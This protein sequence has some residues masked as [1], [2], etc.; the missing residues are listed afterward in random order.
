MSMQRFAL[1]SPAR[2]AAMA[3]LG[4]AL[5]LGAP[6]A[7]LTAAPE[8]AYAAQGTGFSDVASNHWVASEGWLGYATGNGLLTG[9]RD[10]SGRPTGLFGPSD[11]LTRG[12]VAAVLYRIANP[13]SDATSNPA[14]YAASTGFKDQGAYPYYRAAVRWLRDKG[15]ATGDKDPSTQKPLNTFRPD[16]PVTRQELAALV[17]RFCESMGAKGVDASAYDVDGFRDG[18]Q[19]L[20]YARQAMAW[21]GAVG[22]ITGGK[23]AE[24]GLLMPG[25]RT[26]RA[27]AAKVLS[28][29]N[30]L[31]GS[32]GARWGV[33]KG[34]WDE[35]VVTGYATSD[36]KAF[37]SRAEAD[38][39]AKAASKTVTVKTETETVHHD[40]V[41]KQVTVYRT[42]DGREFASKSEADAHAKAASVTV[43]VS[44]ETKTVH[45][46]ATYKKVVDKPAWD[47]KKTVYRT[48]D[49][50]TFQTK[51]EAD[52]H[53]SDVTTGL[54]VTGSRKETRSVDG[55]E[56]ENA[57]GEQVF[58]S[59]DKEQALDYA[60]YNGGLVS[61]QPEDVPVTVHALSDGR[62]VVEV[63]VN[64]Y[65]PAE[66]EKVPNPV[67]G[68]RIWDDS[69]G[70]GLGWYETKAEAD[71]IAAEMNAPYA[72][73]GYAQPYRVAADTLDVG[74]WVLKSPERVDTRPR[75][76]CQDGQSF[77]SLDEAVA[78][79]RATASKVT[80]SESV[81][82]TH[83]DATYKTVVDRPAWDEKVTTYKTS[84]G[85]SF[86]NKKDADDHAK[87][88][89]K[90]VTVSAASKKV[91]D[92]AAYDE[93][94][95]TYRT[96][97]GKAFKSKSEADAHAKATSK[98][99]TVTERA[100]TVRHPAIYGWLR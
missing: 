76:D 91:V 88:A 56:T 92:K 83:H 17:Q 31:A 60:G 42:S 9:Y 12:Q 25:D 2:A 43:T 55:W 44:A 99:V 8:A 24:A 4:L 75:F 23:G 86:T 63:G 66:Y 94:V 67:D 1:K 71:R 19:V 69:T 72:E 58:W 51:A 41:Y 59:V 68:W 73:K 65:V 34:A 62:E 10:A 87:A 3:G 93:K 54:R 26:T 82:V 29:A 20:P 30:G 53:I 47:E 38:A 5:A 79:M 49:G 21:C 100:K 80:V 27:Q 97:D 46:E 64:V 77:D 18:S 11:T 95:V 61:H 70:E 33:T 45:H 35:R 85:K 36:G 90:K 15:I 78:H 74:K 7:A 57:K 81:K 22:A 37:K 84:D 16:D 52:A 39:H 96:S 14:H 98:T 13:S 28:V 48:S 32:R 40:A 6:A 50:K 89:T